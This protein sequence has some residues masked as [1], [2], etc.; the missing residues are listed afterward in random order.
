MIISAVWWYIFYLK[1][2]GKIGKQNSP[3]HRGKND[4]TWNAI[5]I[6]TLPMCPLCGSKIAWWHPRE[7]RAVVPH[8]RYDAAHFLAPVVNAC[9]VHKQCKGIL[10]APSGEGREAYR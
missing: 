6:L 3:I 5:P 7:P 8:S 4:Q 9:V 1:D 2:R 10:V